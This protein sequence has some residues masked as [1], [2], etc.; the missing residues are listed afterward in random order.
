MSLAKKCVFILIHTFS[1]PIQ[2][3]IQVFFETVEKMQLNFFR[4]NDH[5]RRGIGPKLNDSDNLV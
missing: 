5:L 1:E 2:A 4:V 3:V